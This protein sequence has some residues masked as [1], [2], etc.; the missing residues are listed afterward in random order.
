[1]IR[2]IDKLEPFQRAI[3]KAHIADSVEAQ[4]LG[5]NV[6]D[7][8]VYMASCDKIVPA[9]LMA[10]GRINLPG[11]AVVERV[12]RGIKPSDV[13][14]AAAFQNAVTLLASLGGSHNALLHRPANASELGPE[15]TEGGPNAHIQDG[16]IVHIDL[17]SN[18]ISFDVSDEELDARR[19]SQT[20][21]ARPSP[22]ACLHMP[23]AFSC[24]SGIA[25]HRRTSVAA[26]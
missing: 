6:F 15:A 13:M 20:R 2:A 14:T 25:A 26:K 9:M 10:A 4:V 5:E 21:T 16:D 23:G 8:V 19:A 18:A 3:T 1:M 12:R 17:A 7:G 11:A 22:P 24:A